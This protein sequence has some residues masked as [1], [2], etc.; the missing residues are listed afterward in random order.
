MRDTND[1]G[2]VE[3]MVTMTTTQQVD[4]GPITATDR[5]GN[6]A[7]LDGAPTFGSSDEAV[8]TVEA[9]PSGDPAMALAKAVGPTGSVQITVSADADLGEGVKP[10]QG[11]L[12]IDVLAAEASTLVIATGQPTEQ[13]LGA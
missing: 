3:I 8:C 10:I 2:G 13:D 7:P 5:R 9:H 6:P 4:I 1:N 11:I 12:Q